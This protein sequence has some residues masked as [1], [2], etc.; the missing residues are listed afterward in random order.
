MLNSKIKIDLHIHSSSSLYKDGNIVENSN[1]K[2][3]DLLV[4]KLEE[5]E[6]AM[7]SITDHNRFDFILYNALKERIKTSGTVKKILPGIEFDVVLEEGQSRCHIVTIFDDSNEEKLIELWS[8]IQSIKVLNG[9]EEYY[10]IDEFEKILKAINLKT[11]LIAH[12]RQE[13]NGSRHVTQSM[14]D[15]TSN[16]SYFMKIGYIDSLEYNYPRTEGIVKKSLRDLDISFPLIT[17]SDCHQ[18]SAYPFREV[19]KKID[20]DFTQIKSLPTFKGLI[21]SITSFSSRANRSLNENENYI[22][23]IKKGDLEIPLA[24]GLNAVIGDNGSGKSF[25]ANLLSGTSIEQYY[26]KFVIDN[27][28][29]IIKSDTLTLDQIK[30]VKQGEIVKKV[31][32][33]KLFDN[34][35]TD[36]YDDITTLNEFRTAITSYF[37]SIITYLKKKI[38]I[39]NSYTKL[40]QANVE[41]KNTSGDNFNPVIDSKLNIPN[42]KPYKDR[43][44]SIKTIY[45]QLNSEI[46]A[47][48]DFYDIELMSS[49]LLNALKELEEVYKH[50]NSKYFE[51][52]NLKKVMQIVSKGLADYDLKLTEKRTSEES[53]RTSIRQK[54]SDFKNLILDY[55]N[56]LTDDNNYPLFPKSIEGYSSKSIESY[57]F[58]KTAKYHKQDLEIHFYKSLF[59]SGFQSKERIQELNSKEAVSRALT[60][61]DYDELNEFKEKKLEKFIEN[62][63][64]EI[65]TISEIRVN[66]EIGNTP[67]EISL[68]YYKFLTSQSSEDFSVMII[69][70]PEDDINPKRINDFLLD[71]LATVRDKKQ[72]LLITHN[73]MLVVNLDVDNVIYI[74]K[75]NDMFEIK[76]GCLEYD[77]KQDPTTQTSEYSILDLVKE[78]LDG[79]YNVIERR[80][81]SY[82]RD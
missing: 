73:P 37:D 34:A 25:L 40:L 19:G 39:N 23:Y 60:G 47:N 41:I 11:C 79:G 75:K 7:F 13:L 8:K 78:N 21:L 44:N 74:N 58:E 61:Y 42:N 59:N 53:E 82:E 67:G 72:I 36:F 64:Q 14:S 56:D 48:Q 4:Q 32:E 77:T 38:Q 57:N 43:V 18:W 50:L 33:G 2:N 1:I 20:R 68:V 49:K 27:K 70:Q 5:N 6:I 63:T 30:Y 26:S 62:W 35:N 9:K 29:S 45:D 31:R 76:S 10:N 69:D 15:S 65:T 46:Q 51:K 3:I 66:E 22:K 24:N 80:L 81:K 52:E 71:Y 17:G 55:I 16:P 12:Q 28:M 54:Y